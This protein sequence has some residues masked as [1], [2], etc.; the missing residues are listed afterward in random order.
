MLL[1]LMSHSC[2]T[3]WHMSRFMYVSET[4]EKFKECSVRGW[5]R[6][7][8]W[9]KGKDRKCFYSASK[10]GGGEEAIGEERGRRRNRGKRRG[11][12]KFSY[13][14]PLVNFCAVTCSSLNNYFG[15]G[16]EGWEG[17]GGGVMLGMSEFEVVIDQ[18]TQRLTVIS[19][20][21][22]RNKNTLMCYLLKWILIEVKKKIYSHIW[23]ICSEWIRYKKKKDI[24][25]IASEVSRRSHLKH[26]GHGHELRQTRSFLLAYSLSRIPMRPFR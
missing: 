12:W 3:P 17:G 13:R 9:M 11:G 2:P 14:L 10:E 26:P 24:N 8:E 19:D 20:V 16:W 4:T 21:T 23:L 22:T 25:L 6:R 7:N 18:L 15:G 1:S 5:T